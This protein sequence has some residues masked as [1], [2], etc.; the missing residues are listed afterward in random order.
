MDELWFEEELI[1][2]IA[3]VEEI[4][5]SIIDASE[6]TAN[7]ADR[8]VRDTA[9]G[10]LRVDKPRWGGLDV[11]SHRLLSSGQEARF[12]LVRLGFQFDVPQDQRD[13]GTRFVYA[14]CEAYLWPATDGEPQ[15]TVYDVIPR[16]LYEGDLRK[17]SVKIGPKLKMDKMEASIGEVSSDF[18]IGIVEP[19]IVGW[20][21]E[22][23]RA[24]YWDLRPKSKTLLGVR[25]LWLVIEM[26]TGCSGV[27]LTVGAGGDLDTYLGPIPVGPRIRELAR[28]PAILV[29]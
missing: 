17:V 19:V 7:E 28:R 9:R 11:A 8:K 14:R 25:H 5:K 20:P 26:P 24:P 27:R 3:T 12:F 2:T 29:T 18:T 23:E 16:D 15:P 10:I 6:T 4:I 13:L 21:G 1:P 22:N